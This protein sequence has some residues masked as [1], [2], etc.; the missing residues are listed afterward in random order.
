MYARMRLRDMYQL[1]LE[2]NQREND[3]VISPLY[4][5]IWLQRQLNL[6]PNTAKHMNRMFIFWMKGI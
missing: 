4:S 6:K 2:C 1:W 5:R 3:R